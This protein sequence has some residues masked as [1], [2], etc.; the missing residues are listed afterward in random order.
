MTIIPLTPDKPLNARQELFAQAYVSGITGRDAARAAGYRSLSI[1]WDLM[2]K[3]NVVRR[4]E[5]L[6]AE[7]AAAGRLTR[8]TLNEK[9]RDLAERNQRAESVSGQVLSL[10]SWTT[11][12]RMN[13]MMTPKL[14]K[15]AF[16]PVTEI[17]RTVVYPDGYA[18]DYN[19]N[20][21]DPD[22]PPYD[23][24][25]RYRPERDRGEGENS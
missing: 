19:G 5:Q 22:R 20:P 6:Q 21:L 11:L 25:F 12:A 14:E 15:P 13:G 24:S 10:R 3:P 8:D 17:I 2:R 18:T 9:V 16:E 1:V 23:P 7:V 4:I